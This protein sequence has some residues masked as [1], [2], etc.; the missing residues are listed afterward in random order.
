MAITKKS[1]D[2][3]CWRVCGEDETLLHCWSVSKLVQL[4]RKTVWRFLKKLKLELPYD[5]AIPLL[6][7]Y[8]D[9]TTIQ[10]DTCTPMFIIT[11]F[12]KIK[13]CKQ[14]KCP[15]TDECLQKMGNIHNGILLSNKI[16]R[17]NAICSNMDGSRDDQT[18][19]SEVRKRKI[20]CDIT[21]IQNL[22]YNT[23]ELIYQTEVD[24]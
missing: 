16:E 21:Y 4:Q 2:N 8:S 5:P 23:N 12:T 17:N 7:I 3:K 9:K 24:S 11:L 6:D 19:W 20:L 14:S 15:S 10:K 1:T 13:T 18:K 22:K